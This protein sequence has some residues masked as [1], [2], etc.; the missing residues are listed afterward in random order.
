MNK[1]DTLTELI[2]TIQN[3]IVLKVSKELL[4]TYRLELLQSYILGCL[5]YCDN[6][7][8]DILIEL[9]DLLA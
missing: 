1:L 5:A 3:P 9:K 2:S 6:D 7:D 4:D 8:R